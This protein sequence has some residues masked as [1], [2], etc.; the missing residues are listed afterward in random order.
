MLIVFYGKDT[1]E[2]RRMHGK[3]LAELSVSSGNVPVEKMSGDEWNEAVFFDSVCCKSF[4]HPIRI[5]SGRSLFENEDAKE[6]I[7]ANKKEIAEAENIV[8]LLE[9]SVRA[10][11]Y[12]ALVEA[13]AECIVCDGKDAFS[14]QKKSGGARAVSYNIFAFTNAIIAR[15]RRLAWRLFHEGVSAGITPDELYFK[16]SWAIRMMRLARSGY[17]GGV[18]GSPY[19]LRGAKRS[20]RCY[21]NKELTELSEEFLLLYENKTTGGMEFSL[22]L[23]G[24]L[25]TL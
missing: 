11:D 24:K 1:D 4:F 17:A 19:T 14:N 6:C 22:A 13:G 7:I 8:V 2:A 10:A 20:E 23:E 9:G 18:H 15:D 21:T 16:I 3:R 5:L 12:A 25:L